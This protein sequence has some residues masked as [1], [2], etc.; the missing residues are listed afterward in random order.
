MTY[1]LLIRDVTKVKTGRKVECSTCNDFNIAMRQ[2]AK[3]W[4]MIGFMKC[5][6]EEV[7]MCAVKVFKEAKI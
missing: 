2:V 3:G 6:P 7:M 1:Y 4:K 5:K